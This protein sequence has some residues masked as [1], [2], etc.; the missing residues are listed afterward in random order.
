[1]TTRRHGVD[2]LL[3]CWLRLCLFIWSGHGIRLIA[4]VSSMG[5]TLGLVMRLSSRLCSGLASG[6]RNSE[7]DTVLAMGAARLAGHN[8][9]SHIDR[10]QSQMGAIAGCISYSHLDLGGGEATRFVGVDRGVYNS[11]N[12]SSWLSLGDVITLGIIIASCGVSS[13]DVVANCLNDRSRGCRC[14]DLHAGETGLCCRGV[15]VGC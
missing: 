5:I 2:V 13:G 10:W 1:M 15:D 9:S 3:A 14:I 8:N 6:S 7:R 12:G 4:G 11:G